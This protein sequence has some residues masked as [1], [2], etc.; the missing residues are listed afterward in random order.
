MN[1]TAPAFDGAFERRQRSATDDRSGNH[2][3]AGQLIVQRKPGAP[4]EN[5]NLGRKPHHLGNTGQIGIAIL[6]GHMGF[7]QLRCLAAP[8]LHALGN[9][10]HGVD[11][12][13][14]ARHGI[15][16]QVGARGISVGLC[17]GHR[18]KLLIDEPDH[19][20]R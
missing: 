19:E 4:A 20:Q 15:G 1:E 18:R 9:H 12:L 3:A 2:H 16:R 11:H 6:G 5:G 13:R 8:D 10:A 17:E 7:E 14:I